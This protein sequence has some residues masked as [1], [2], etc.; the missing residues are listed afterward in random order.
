MKSIS[1]FSFTC[2]YFTSG[3]GH[4]THKTEDYDITSNIIKDS[5][6]SAGERNCQV[7]LKKQLQIA[8][9]DSAVRKPEPIPDFQYRANTRWYTEMF[10]NAIM[11]APL[12]P[13]IAQNFKQ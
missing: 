12:I 10:K 6:E 2:G 1:T 9:I 4:Y 11:V 5:L 8:Y 7:I 3:N 13:M